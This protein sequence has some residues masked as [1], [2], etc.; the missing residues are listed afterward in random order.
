[1][2]ALAEGQSVPDAKTQEAARVE[3]Y[4]SAE[5]EC[6][7]LSE[8]YKAECRLSQVTINTI[9]AAP[10]SPPPNALSATATYE[11]KPKH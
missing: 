7:Q 8:I 6:A 11:L 1:V 10:N 9:I 3:L 2:A 5:R 4:R